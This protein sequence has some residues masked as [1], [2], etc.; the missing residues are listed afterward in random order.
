LKTHANYFVRAILISLALCMLPQFATAD[1]EWENVQKF[2]LQARALD[3]TTSFDGKT[4]FMLTPGEVLIYSIEDNKISARIPVDASFTR[5]AY[6]EGDKLVLSAGDPS[7][8]TIIQYSNVFDIDIANRPA[9]GP[10]TAPVTLVIF[11]DYQ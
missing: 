2:P 1:I 6:T 4:A 5:I 7:N 11:D 9:K 10:Q 3:V 8:I